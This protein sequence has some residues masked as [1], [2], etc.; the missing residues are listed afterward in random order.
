MAI[1]TLQLI[2]ACV[3]AIAFLGAYGLWKSA[4]VSRQQSGLPRGNVVYSDTGAWERSESLFAP[5][6]G[7][8]GKPDYVVQ[9]GRHLIPVEVKPNRRP[10]PGQDAQPYASDVMQLAAYCLL[11]EETDGRRPPYGLLRYRDTTF[12][13]RFHASVRRALM[14]QLRQMRRDLNRR[15]VPRSHDD[16]QR[17]RTC[18]HRAHCGQSLVSL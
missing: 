14:R 17:C 15:G 13:L 10:A 1:D 16:P 7:L 2:L 18:G 12:H 11:V 5:E 4:R 3:T 9:S 8:A 6:L